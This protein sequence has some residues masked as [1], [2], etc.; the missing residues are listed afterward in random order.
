VPNSLEQALVV[1]LLQLRINLLHRVQTD[2]HDD[3]NAGATKGEVLIGVHRRQAQ[4]AESEQ[5][6]KI[7]RAWQRDT[8]QNVV[9]VLGGGASRTDT[10][11]EA[12]VALHVV[13]D[14]FGVEDDGDI[15]VGKAHNQRK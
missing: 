9:E 5:Q 6:T 11:D 7:E 1:T 12:A 14:L 10:G 4:S 2:T 3:Q 8:G 15:E 13:G